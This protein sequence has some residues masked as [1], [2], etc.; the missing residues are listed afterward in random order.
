VL[1]A[2]GTYSIG[3]ERIVKAIAHALGSKIYCDTRKRGLLLAQADPSLHA[4]LTS[5]PYT[6]QVHLLPLQNIS[7]ERMTEY[8]AHFKGVFD[9]VLGFRPTGWTYVAPAGTDTMP[10]VRAVIGRDQRRVFDETGLRP[11]RGASERCMLYGVPYSEHRYV[12]L[13]SVPLLP[14]Q[15]VHA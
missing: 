2:I 5:D 9:R 7:I 6:C 14:Y 1:V 4:L 15:F 12:F 11:M 8:L 13:L 10:D 3:K